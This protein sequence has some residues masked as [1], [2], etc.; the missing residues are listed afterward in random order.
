VERNEKNIS[1]DAMERLAIALKVDLLDLLVR[2]G[3]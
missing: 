3:I 1:I 2:E